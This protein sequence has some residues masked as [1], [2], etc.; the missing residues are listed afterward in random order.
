MQC[1][2]CPWGMP[3][4]H[5]PLAERA[6]NLPPL[7][8]LNSFKHFQ[9][10]IKQCVA[11]HIVSFMNMNVVNCFEAIHTGERNAE[12]HQQM[13]QMPNI[14]CCDI[15][16]VVLKKRNKYVWFK[17]KDW[18]P[19]KSLLIKYKRENINQSM[20]TT[21]IEKKKKIWVKIFKS[22]S[23]NK[24][25]LSPGVYHVCCL[26]PMPRASYQLDFSRLKTIYHR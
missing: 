3:V 13:I 22:T 17:L 5:Y 26:S 4:H 6:S 14:G 24:I 20:I 25:I 21:F 12:E 2:E 15:C 9:I 19:P 23:W 11:Q 7:K 18:N 10:L 8:F 1:C 16:Y